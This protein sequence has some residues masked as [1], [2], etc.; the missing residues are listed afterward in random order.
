MA[1]RV[2]ERAR[3]WALL[4]MLARA[5]VSVGGSRDT[6]LDRTRHSLEEEIGARSSYRIRLLDSGHTE[7]QLSELD[8]RLSQL[9]EQ[10]RET[11]EQIQLQNHAYGALTHPQ[12][13]T[14]QQVQA[15]LDDDTLLL[16][17][18]L[19]QGSSYVWAVTPATLATLS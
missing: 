7:G 8:R 4:E 1:L 10:Y 2:M 3:A 14:G 15:L 9:Q 17:Y 5:R 11:E 19:G 18:S 16:E 13:S 12:T 6:R